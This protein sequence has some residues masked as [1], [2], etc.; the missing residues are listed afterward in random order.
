MADNDT[1]PRVRLER[2][3]VERLHRGA[4]LSTAK[5]LS[6]REHDLEPD[7]FR[8]QFHRDYTRIIHSRAF[9]RLRH[10]TQVF[11]APKNDHVCTRLEH[12][13]YV[14]SV[15][16]T[17]A[18]ALELNEDLVRAI[19]AGHD[20]GDAPFGHKGERSLAEIVKEHGLSFSHELHSLRV[21]DHLESPYKE[22]RGLNLTFAVRDGIVCHC[23]EKFERSLRPDR[24]KSPDDLKATIPRESRPATLE[25]CVVRWADK[26]A[27]LGR[28]MEDA[29]TLK[30]IQPEDVPKAVRRTLG[31]S[32]REIIASLIRELA[33]GRS[34]EDCISIGQ[35][36][37]T[38]LNEF[39]EFNLEKIYRTPEATHHFRQIDRAAR[40]LFD[41]LLQELSSVKGD[42]EK[43]KSSPEQCLQV[44]AEFLTDDVRDWESEDKPRLV[45]DYIAGMTDSFF[46]AS[47]VQLFL[48]QSSV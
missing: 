30:I 6:E 13:L 23:G 35:E 36:M 47:F 38:A 7:D 3:E 24:S 15:A 4:T 12:S 14:A 5:T 8:T 45:L 11:I 21:V 31:C 46:I 9:R 32:N 25:G 33:R 43:L 28:D 2:E 48:P 10:K 40:F 1:I 41:F 17:I 18:R 16:T 26:V 29:I 39:F 42:T 34:D 44:F 37:N 27:Y 22:H 19:A 20:L